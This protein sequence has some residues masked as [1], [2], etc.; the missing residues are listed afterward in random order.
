MKDYYEILGVSK[1]ASEKD[2]KKSYRKL[3]LKYHPDKNANKSPE[4]KQEA[5][6]KF[7]EVNEAFQTLGDK[8]KRQQYDMFGSLGGDFRGNGFNPFG[9]RTSHGYGPNGWFDP[10]E[11][12]QAY[13]RRQPTTYPPGSN[14]RMKIPVT[15]EEIFKGCTKKVKFERKI[16]CAACHGDGGYNKKTCSRCGGSGTVVSVSQSPFGVIRQETTCPVCKG[17]GFTYEKSCPTCSGTGYTS[18]IETLD[19]EIPM[20]TREFS[21]FEYKGKGNESRSKYMDTG[22]FLA[23]IIYDYDRNR[24][25]VEGLNI[26]EQLTLPY[27]ELMLGT[28]YVLEKPDGKQL[29]I[30]IDSCPPEGKTIRLL[31]EGLPGDIQNGDYFLQL[32]YGIPESISDTERELLEAIKVDKTV[33]KNESETEII[34]EDITVNDTA[35]TSE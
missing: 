5:E 11:A 12:G 16:R 13:N 29:K 21:T 31:G 20:G 7:K 33:S 10:F 25:F 35:E 4:E 34:D 22:D 19:V 24:Y 23:S 18:R 30:H 26:L 14:I 2:I 15:L 8:E 32:H 27:Y 28:D 6:A 17:V 1:D 3:S 9:S